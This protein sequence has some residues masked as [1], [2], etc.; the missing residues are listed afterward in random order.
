MVVNIVRITIDHVQFHFLYLF[1]I[2]LQI[3]PKCLL[4]EA[5]T[6][7]LTPERLSY[8]ILV[9]CVAKHTAPSESF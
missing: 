1:V 8:N 3:F 5:A 7:A 9:T 6:E 2:Y 4:S